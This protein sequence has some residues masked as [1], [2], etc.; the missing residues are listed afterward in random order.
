MNFDMGELRTI[1]ELDSASY[2]VL[3]CSRHVSSPFANCI[4]YMNILDIA[5]LYH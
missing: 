1:L 3:T 2:I 5:T 4:F